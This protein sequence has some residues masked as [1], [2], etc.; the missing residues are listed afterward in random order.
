MS[1]PG[2]FFD[3]DGV[4]NV[5]KGYLH[6]IEDLILIPGAAQ[7]VRALNDLGIFCCLISNQS[8]PA[9]NYYPTSH[10]EALHERLAQLLW[11]EAQAKLNAYYYCPY[12]SPNNGGINP[13]Y[14]C[15]S[16]WRKP[17]T[18]MLVAAA[19]DYDLDLHNS[20][21]IGDKATDID[22][23]HNAGARGILVTTGYGTRVLQGEYQHPSKPDYIA[24]DVSAGVNW[25]INQ[26]VELQARK[27]TLM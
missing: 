2:V 1:K 14:A 6:N 24:A 26:I 25:V 15:C 11:Q 3:R 4:L 23:A 17:N 7:S 27:E 20:Y 8:G 9:R 10:I 18:G 16:S 13:K 12:L 5:E 22:L 21:V 19:W